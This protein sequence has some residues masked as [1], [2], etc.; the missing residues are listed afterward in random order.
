[1]PE[2]IFV[3]M[4]VLVASLGLLS[5]ISDANIK[6][7]YQ[8]GYT[9]GYTAGENTI[10]TFGYQEGGLT[11]IESTTI[12]AGLSAMTEYQFQVDVNTAGKENYI[13]TTGSA[14]DLEWGIVL[15]LMNEQCG[16]VCIFLIVDGDIRCMSLLAGSSSSIEMWSGAEGNDLFA[17]ITGWSEEPPVQGTIA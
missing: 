17:S 14:S 15:A 7:A 3:A 4:I 6:G 11:G 1:M 16:D 9:E 8:Q 12:V 5:L 2:T 10:A 13:I